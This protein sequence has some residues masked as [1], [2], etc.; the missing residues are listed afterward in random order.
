MNAIMREVKSVNKTC[1]ILILE[2]SIYRA[3]N[4]TKGKV[5]LH[6]IQEINKIFASL[7]QEVSLY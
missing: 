7:L 5:D 3:M 4:E 2:K 1:N 6:R